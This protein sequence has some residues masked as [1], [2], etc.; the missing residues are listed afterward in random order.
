MSELAMC[1]VI[2]GSPTVRGDLPYVEA[3][4]ERE[5]RRYVQWCERYPDQADQ[6]RLRAAVTILGLLAE[7]DRLRD[8]AYQAGVAA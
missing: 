1:G 7:C 5:A 2:W 3:I 8:L 4:S 6:D